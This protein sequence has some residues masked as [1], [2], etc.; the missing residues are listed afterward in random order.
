MRREE[1]ERLIELDD[2]ALENEFRENS[3]L[4]NIIEEIAH[5]NFYGETPSAAVIRSALRRFLDLDDDVRES[6]SENENTE[7]E[8][9]S[10]SN[11]DYGDCDDDFDY[12]PIN[13]NNH[14]GLYLLGFPADERKLQ[15]LDEQL[16]LLN[17]RDLTREAIIT[18][19]M[20]ESLGWTIYKRYISLALE[21]RIPLGRFIDDAVKW[22]LTNEDVAEKMSRMR[23]MLQILVECLRNVRKVCD[24]FVEDYIKLAAI[25]ILITD[26]EEKLREVI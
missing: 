2:E 18:H 19:L 9:E 13:I 25:K 21:R 26:T 16:Q 10:G 17:L 3:E 24:S 4:R 20:I 5:T 22:Y 6:I 1:I 15:A 8:T 12:N 23:I 14:N 11:Y 7:H